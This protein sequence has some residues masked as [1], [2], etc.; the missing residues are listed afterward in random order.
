M[1]GAALEARISEWRGFVAR[2]RID[3]AEADEL[4]SHLRDRIEELRTAGLDDDEAFLVAVKRLGAV[5]ALSREFARANSARLW[6]QLVAPAAP[7]RGGGL[8]SAV[9]LGG[10]AAAAFQV[11]RVARTAGA[12][13]TGGGIV[14]TLVLRSMPVVALLALVIWLLLRRRSGVANALAALV[15]LTV[16]TAA[17]DSYPLALS[18]A[19]LVLVLTHLPVALWLCVGVAYAGREWRSTQRRMDFVRFTGEFVVYYVLIALG[20][21][22]LLVLANAILGPVIPGI[23]D[24]LLQWGVY[25]GAVWAF[26]VAA[27]LVESKQSVIENIAPVLAKIFTPLFALMIAAAVV[28]YAVLGLGTAFNRDLLTVFDALLVVVLGLV[29]YGL[30]ARVDGRPERLLDATGLVAVV[31]ALLLDA[32]VLASLAG[33]IGDL[34][35]TANRVA[36]LGLNLVLFVVLAGAAWLGAAHLAR[37]APIARLER[38][39]T[40]CLPVYGVWAA[41]VAIALPPAFGFA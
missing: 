4:E 6:K 27:W 41:F 29:L 22:V 31:G 18:S 13:D 30:S 38:W 17:V 39:Q 9:L 34:G 1:A 20:G 37:R 10:L 19:A 3:A 33:R 25:S 35:W 8:L 23:A 26:P 14:D 32:L 36:A 15:P 11:L 12:P 28:V 5:D 21:A 24:G 16:V 2:G 40:G 7:A